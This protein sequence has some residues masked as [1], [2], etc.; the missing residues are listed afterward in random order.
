[1]GDVEVVV[2]DAVTVVGGETEATVTVADVETC[3]GIVHVI[4][5]VLL[6]CP[7]E[8][9]T[10][11]VNGP[12]PP[13]AEPQPPVTE[14]TPT[15]EQPNAVVSDVASAATE[16][17]LTTLVTLVEAAGLVEPINAGGLT[18]FAPTNEAFDAILKKLGITADV[19]IADKD[20]LREILTYHVLPDPFTAADFGDG[21]D[22]K[23]VL[24]DDSTC[25]VGS[26]HIAVHDGVTIFGGATKA[27]VVTADVTVGTSV[28]HVID[29]VLLPCRLA[30]VP[31]RPR[32]VRKKRGR[33][34]FHG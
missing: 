25:G 30:V 2:G 21:G 3:T 15:P 10:L 18:V 27:N 31:V 28:V 23:T 19:L 8:G 13:V 9:V 33:F 22:F 4:D 29:N 16:A 1:M 26:V 34:F 5:F 17:G 6:P 20:L 7:L 14:P 32:R 12:Q 11:P 24:G